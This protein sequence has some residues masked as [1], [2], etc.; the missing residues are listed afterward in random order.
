MRLNRPHRCRVRSDGVL[1][2]DMR[3]SSY[4]YDGTFVRYTRCA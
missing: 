4:T 3:R 1:M 2:Q